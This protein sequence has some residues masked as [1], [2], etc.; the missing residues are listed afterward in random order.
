MAKGT[1]ALTPDPEPEKT[2]MGK[3]TQAILHVI[4]TVPD[5]DERIEKNPKERAQSLITTA[6]MKAA[7]VAGVLALPP[8]PLGLLTVIPDL[9]TIWHIQRQLVADIAMVYGKSRV[10]GPEV[11]LWCL[12]KHGGAQAV[13][14]LL[15]KA[16]EKLLVRRT[17]LKGLQQ[18]AGKIGIRVT[19]KLLGRGLSRFLLV[20]GAG[21][22]AYIAYSD[23]TSIGATCIETFEKEIEIED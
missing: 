11:M 1:N 23:T 16:G 13:N 5:S 12:F 19:Q 10:L 21:I 3:V 7:G 18:I 6:S 14:Q 8:G 4:S 15:I 9:V 22:M 20:L 17:T 2:L